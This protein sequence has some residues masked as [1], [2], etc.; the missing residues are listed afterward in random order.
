MCAGLCIYSSPYC[1]LPAS[2]FHEEMLQFFI[3]ENLYN[4]FIVASH[5]HRVDTQFHFLLFLEDS[6]NKDPK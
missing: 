4:I 5:G 6:I 3:L 1:T 2:Y